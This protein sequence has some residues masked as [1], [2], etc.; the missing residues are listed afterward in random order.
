MRKIIVKADRQIYQTHSKGIKDQIKEWYSLTIAQ[1]AKQDQIK[2][3][4]ELEKLVQ[5]SYYLMTTDPS[6]KNIE[7]ALRVYVDCVE[8]W[9]KE[10]DQ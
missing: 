10:Y 5:V 2:D 1:L 3:D 8:I 4:D 6:D 9:V 7:D